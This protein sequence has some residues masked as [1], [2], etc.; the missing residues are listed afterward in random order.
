VPEESLGTEMNLPNIPDVTYESVLAA[1]Q[2]GLV[3]SLRSR[4]PQKGMKLKVDE[5]LWQIH[6]DLMHSNNLE[7]Q[8]LNTSAIENITL[9]GFKHLINITLL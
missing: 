5:I 2:A 9:E 3:Y 6:L 8:D 1:L 7:D 4:Q